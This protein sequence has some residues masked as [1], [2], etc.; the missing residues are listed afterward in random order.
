ML[1]TPYREYTVSGLVM[2]NSKTRAFFD[3]NAA[4][5]Q[6]HPSTVTLA[7]GENLRAGAYKT[8]TRGAGKFTWP[9]ESGFSCNMLQDIAIVT[10]D[11]AAATL[12]KSLHPGDQVTLTGLSAT[13][14][15]FSKKGQPKVTCDASFSSAPNG[16]LLYIPAASGV[17]ILRRGNR[18]AHTIFL[19]SLCLSATLLLGYLKD[20]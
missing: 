17:K 11:K 16:S 18:A 9:P 6:Q 2:K 13:E 5:R 3:A 14:I 8:V 7:F 19:L 20:K 12:V 4:V 15:N 1:V 10:P